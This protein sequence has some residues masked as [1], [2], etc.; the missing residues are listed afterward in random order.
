M[1]QI[2]GEIRSDVLFFY[3]GRVALC[4][5]LKA[6]GIE[7]QDQVAMQAFTCIA[8][9]EALMAAG[10]RPIYVDVESNGFN[11]DADDLARKLTPKTR[12]IVVQ[13]TFGIPADMDRILRVARQAG[14]PIIEDCCHTLASEYKGK[15]LGAFGVASFYSS[16]WGKPIVAGIGG[17]AVVNDPQLRERMHRAY[18]TY[19][20]PGAAAL[21]RIQLQYYAFALLYRPL[22]FWPVRSLFHRLSSLGVAV[23]NYN[24][25]GEGNIAEDFS[26]R[27]APALQRRLARKLT[28]LDAQTH[29]SRWVAGEYQARIRSAAVAHPVLPTGSDTVFARYPLLATNKPELLAAARR[30]NVELSEWYATPVHP[31]VDKELRLVHYEPGSCPN[32]E[33]RCDEIV[34]LPT[35]PAVSKRDVDRAIRFLNE[36]AP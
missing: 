8:V 17:S 28:K 26:L 3:R 20:T 31:L 16:E 14:L 19:R 33:A 35:H 15:P 25:M 9:P 6:L 1:S 4:A 7:Q 27:M 5:I 11:M 29:H 36:V 21:S 10:A 18:Q 2:G 32:A 22:L 34:A 13:H 12:A 24:P 30:A 23:N